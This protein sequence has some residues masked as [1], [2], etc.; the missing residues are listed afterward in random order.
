MI[1]IKPAILPPR[2]AA[3][4][5]YVRTPMIGSLMAIMPLW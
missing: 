3:N 4:C 1:A 2:Q 5:P